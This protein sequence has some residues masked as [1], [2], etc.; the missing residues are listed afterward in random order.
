MTT[1]RIVDAGLLVERLE[2]ALEGIPGATATLDYAKAT[3]GARRGVALVTPPRLKF[4]AGTVYEAAWPVHLVAGPA[5]DPEAAWE[6]LD[7]MLEAVLEAG[8]PVT[9]AEPSAYNTAQGE[10]LPAYTITING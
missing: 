4:P 3:N 8:L 1:P 10:S 6:K 9:E 5:R 2:L 7:L